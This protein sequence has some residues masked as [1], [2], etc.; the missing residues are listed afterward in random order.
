MEEPNVERLLE[1]MARHHEIDLPIDRREWV[2]HAWPENLLPS[3]RMG[4]L[5]R[6]RFRLFLHPAPGIA[7]RVLLL[8]PRRRG[9]ALGRDHPG[10][11]EVTG[12]P[13]VPP[14]NASTA[15]EQLRLPSLFLAQSVD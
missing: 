13:L 10:A 4:L 7:A 6:L 5:R 15:G 8:R 14:A 11:R 12:L 2:V 9:T 3:R 1:D